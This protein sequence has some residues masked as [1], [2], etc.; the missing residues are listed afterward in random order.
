LGVSFFVSGYSLIFVLA[1]VVA[2]MSAGLGMRYPAPWVEP[3]KLN[4]VVRTNARIPRCTGY[5]PEDPK[6]GP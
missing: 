3:S 5:I 6:T 1:Q 4:Y 2:C